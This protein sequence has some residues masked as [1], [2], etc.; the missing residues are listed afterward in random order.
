MFLSE[1][2]AAFRTL[3]KAVPRVRLY[4][5][6][7][8][9]YSTQVEYK[10]I[11]SVLVANRGEIAIRVFR[12]CTELG[13]KSVAVYSEQDK[14]HMHRQKAD[15]SYMVG[16]GLAP[17]EA[18]LNIP[19]IIRVCKENDI[20]AVHPGYG[21]LSE[22]SDFAQA[23][24]D[25]GLR[26]I[27]PSPKVVQNMGDKVAARIAAIEAGVPIVPG[28]D[29]PI[30]S[31]EEALAF[32]Q[33]HGL[34]VIF[35][36]AYGGGGRGMR[37]V[38]K[39]EE[40]EE[41]FERASSEAKAAFGNGAMFI[42][43]F[44]E[45]PRHIEVQLLGDK[46]GN[47]VHLYERDCSVQRRHQKVVEIAPAPRLPAETRD[48]MTEAAVRL[49]KHVGYENA[50]TVEFLCDESGNFY[51]IE[52]NA[53]L[54]VEHTVTEEITGIDLVQSQ[55]RIA[56]GMTLK[57][58]GLTQ[59]NVVPR[60][61]AIQCRV[62]TEDPANDF[63]PNT[64]R[65]EVFR[66][67]EGMGIRLD[68]ASTYA[69]A[70]ISPYYDSLLV[71]VISHA[72][73]LQSSASKMNRALREFRIRGVKTN[74]PF[75]LNVLENQKF[76][77]G[78]LDTYFIDE[79][80]QLFK[81]STTQNRAQKLLNYLGEVLVNGPQ[82]PLATT[83]KP[84][85]VNPHVP[86]VPLDLS[87]EALEREKSGGA[88]VTEPP[89]GLRDIIVRE[90]PQ[91]FAKEV[92]SRKNLLLM[93]TTF[94]DAHQSLMAT[95]VRT[96]DLL[97]IS[98]YVAHKFNNLYSLE[99]WGGATFDVALRFLHEC[100]WERLEEMRKRIPNIPFQML[101]RG[102]NAVGYTSYPD[103]VVYK[104]CE[105][106]V[107]TGMDIFRVFDSLNYLP[108]LILGMEAAG[109]AGGVVEAAISY[110]GDVSDPK[111]TKYDLKYY[112]NLADELVKAGT[113][114]LCI[115][116]MAGLLK[117]ESARLLITAIR[118]KHP[119]VP[120]HVHT[121][122]T[123]GAGVASML[124]CAQAGADVVDVAVDSMSGM[125]SQPSMGA[126]VASLQGTPLDTQ[127]DLGDVSEYSAY[128]EQTRTLYGPFECTTTM[129]SGNA[130][131]YLNEIP[132]GQYTNLQF[133]AFSLGLGDMFEDVKK[134]Y[135]EANFVLGDIIK[136][137]PSS[138]V[139]GDLAQ[140][141]V[142]NNLNGAQVVEK[143]E[144]LSF[145]KSVIEYL[146]GYIGIPYGGFPEPFRTRVLKDMPR[147]EGRPGA[148]M[149]PLDFDKLKSE[150]S[151]SHVNV[152]D[153]D[154]VSAALYPQVTNEFLHYRE[155]Y[156]PV[157]KLD[158]RIFLSGPKVGEEFE[159][160]LERGKTLSMKALAMAA[161]LKPNGKREVFFE[162]NGQLRSV[163]IPDKEAMKEIRIHPKADKTVK[164]EVGAPMPGDVID[165][166]VTIGDKV[167]KGQPLVVLS[168]MKM[169]MVVQAPQSGVVKKV[170]VKKGMKL[171]GDDLILIIE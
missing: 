147:I 46:A 146:Q 122:D 72:S 6:N 67:G 52:V 100:P 106:A 159:V 168:A 169:E 84:S 61:F 42:E 123:S 137:T 66:S 112:T 167:E 64:G 30:T 17:V 98:P 32:C 140:F 55:I 82:T 38:R 157:D 20:D 101:L 107:Q 136:V 116:D 131:V 29:G 89:Q 43:K 19:E 3:R 170:E 9:A 102:A 118:D 78:V 88:K 47:V 28:T 31:K 49:A 148:E 115:K 73:D 35:K 162:L 124:S 104:F 85:E 45:R 65:L 120:I 121:H 77:H 10:P 111:R 5:I 80:P 108:N 68:S 50:G 27:G 119:D 24:I 54:Q 4:F 134:A 155:Q 48:K 92:R 105:L 149:A 138:K 23:V 40:V 171:D 132:G 165:V 22:R 86:Q 114:V 96:H 93:D 158:T 34:P 156:G 2:Q 110:T 59:E 58:L 71:K 21:F 142:Q 141:M 81:F 128:W 53:R 36:A 25:A 152:T 143:A 70:I 90:G 95:R 8:N 57:E 76:L 164:G 11:R 153:R 15:E 1:S 161:D 39:M 69:G 126:V 160:T 150:L 74:I 139:V 109:K 63:Q 154:V 94:R 127:L 60:G 56:E 44:I 113:H 87:P 79:H 91:A 130:D 166:R 7:K 13:I 133:Q 117:P 18:Y 33:K 16:K 12:A 14:M 125:T 97:K 103:N 51:F 26:F 62:T 41:N 163:H 37:V 145:P 144:E 129:R 135:R 151:E 83:L 99:N 75:L